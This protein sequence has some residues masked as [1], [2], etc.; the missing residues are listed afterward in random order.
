MEV[1]IDPEPSPEE[2]KAILAA[3]SRLLDRPA[4]SDSAW[5]REGVLENVSEEPLEP[6]DAIP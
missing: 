5:W 1:R 3:L 6:P 2:R 4:E